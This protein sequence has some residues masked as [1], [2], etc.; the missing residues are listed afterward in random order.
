MRIIDIL[1]ILSDETNVNIW[2]GNEIIAAY[3]SKNSIP[4]Y[5]NDLPIKSI[6]SGYYCIDIDV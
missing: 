5:L 4:E 1:S 3:D 2:D 6:T